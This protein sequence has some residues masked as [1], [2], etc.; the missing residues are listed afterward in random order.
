MNK[1]RLKRLA[2]IR[3][4]TSDLESALLTLKQHFKVSWTGPS[5]TKLYYLVRLAKKAP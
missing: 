2:A 4:A 3:A 1:K 5:F